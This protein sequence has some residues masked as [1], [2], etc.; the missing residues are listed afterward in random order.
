VRDLADEC[1]QLTRILAQSIVTT[2]RNIRSDK[3]SPI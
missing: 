3:P 1:D 2:K